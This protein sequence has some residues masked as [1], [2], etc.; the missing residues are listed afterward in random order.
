MQFDRQ[1][2]EILKL[3]PPRDYAV[4]RCIEAWDDLGTERPIG[5]AVGAIP[6][7]SMVAWSAHHG[8]GYEETQIVVHVLRTLDVDRARA[9]AADR[10]KDTALGRGRKGARR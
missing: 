8:L 10:S 3:E 5:F 6:W 2:D 7:S 9:E 1:L 4:V